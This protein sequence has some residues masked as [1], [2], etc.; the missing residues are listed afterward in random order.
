MKTNKILLY[1]FLSS[2][3]LLAYVAFVGYLMVNGNKLFG[4]VPH[5]AAMMGFLLL[6]VFSALLTGLLV[7]G[8]PIY[9]YL[10]KKKKIAIK[11]LFYNAGWLALMTIV[12]LLILQIM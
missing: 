10:E 8:G 7:L 2:C 9:L 4:H 6:F 3:G 12:V 11:M 5:I 1:S